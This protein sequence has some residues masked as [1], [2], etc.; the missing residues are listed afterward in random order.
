MSTE[1]VQ[2]GAVVAGGMHVFA[3]ERIDRH[4]A[5]IAAVIDPAFLA[6]V[7]W[8]LQRRVLSFAAEQPD[9]RFGCLP[10]G[11]VQMRVV[12]AGGAQPLLVCLAVEPFGVAALAGACG[13][14]AES[15]RRKRFHLPVGEELLDAN[16]RQ[17]APLVLV[18]RA[19]AR[20]RRAPFPRTAVDE[21]GVRSAA[22]PPTT[23]RWQC[24]DLVLAQP[25]FGKSTA[26]PGAD[27]RRG[28]CGRRT[29]RGAADAPAQQRA[30][31]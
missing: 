31:W 2:A 7:G 19:Q 20:R 17:R 29:V 12:C 3:G 21:A 30:R 5:A 28:R 8:D 13:D 23:A 26:T 1:A 15:Q 18:G 4:A 11:F 10:P 24:G 14:R 16:A 6:E 27:P 9:R 22:R 25:M